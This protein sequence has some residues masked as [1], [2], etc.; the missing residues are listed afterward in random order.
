[1]NAQR[2]TTAGS[3]AKKSSRAA[4]TAKKASAGASAA[5]TVVNLNNKAIQDIQSSLSSE[6]QKAQEQFYNMGRES[7]EQF[8]KSAD[9]AGQA[10]NE[11]SNICRENI[12][13]CIES[14]NIAAS[15]A[16]EVSEE[17]TEYASYSANEAVELS[18]ALFSCR[19]LNDVVELQN[20]VVK[21][22]V[23]TSF[24]QWSRLSNSAF[25]S[26][27]EIVEPINQRIAE[28]TD[29]LNKLMSQK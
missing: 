7:A 14:S 29:Q 24:E 10:V 26:F 16:K 18:K 23:E 13:A 21:N 5:E 28:S 19:T 25:E 17:L 2:K 1:M 15:I 4:S 9:G 12:E 8:A 6:A 3:S 20:K 11:A 27:N 22:S